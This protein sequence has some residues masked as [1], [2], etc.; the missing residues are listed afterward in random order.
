L[1]VEIAPLNQ[2]PAVLAFG[3]LEKKF[4]M[5]QQHEQSES[6]SLKDFE[7]QEELLGIDAKSHENAFSNPYVIPKSSESKKDKKRSAAE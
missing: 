1:P 7:R 3:H 6:P 5:S 2:K 4:S